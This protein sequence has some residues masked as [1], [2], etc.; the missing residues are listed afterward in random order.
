VFCFGHYLQIVVGTSLIGTCAISLFFR[1]FRSS[2][3]CL[4][5]AGV[6]LELAEHKDASLQGFVYNTELCEICLRAF[7]IHLIGN[8]K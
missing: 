5:V 1:A 7:V 3:H 2:L 8:W 6:T 4:T